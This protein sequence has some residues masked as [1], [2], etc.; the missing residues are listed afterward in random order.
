[1]ITNESYGATTLSVKQGVTPEAVVEAARSWRDASFA[2]VEDVMSPEWLRWFAVS[3][4]PALLEVSE[5][6]V[7]PSKMHEGRPSGG[8]RL[9]RVDPG[10]PQVPEEVVE[11]MAA[12][13]DKYDL[14]SLGERLAGDLAPIVS[15]VLGEKVRYDRIYFL[16]YGLDDYISPH[17]DKHVGP[18]VNVQLPVCVD[19]I[20]GLRV[21]Q[22]DWKTYVDKS[23]LLRFLGPGIWHEVLPLIGEPNAMRLNITLRYWLTE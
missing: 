11:R 14:W 13:Y 9:H 17:D 19:G 15:A 1:M 7:V 5:A 20:A 10:R 23:G 4:Y 3:L 12:V 8:Q 18:R 6:H 22:D 2:E 16:L 21:H